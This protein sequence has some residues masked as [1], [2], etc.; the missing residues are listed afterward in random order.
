MVHGDLGSLGQSPSG[1]TRATIDTEFVDPLRARMAFPRERRFALIPAAGSGMRAGLSIP[2]QYEVIAGRPMIDWTLDAFRRSRLVD[3]TYVILSRD[4]ARFTFAS[5]A[6]VPMYV[7]GK[8]R[9]DSVLA[10]LDAIAPTTDARDWILVH[11]AA[12]PG[13]DVALLDHT[14]ERLAQDEVGGLLALPIADTLKR[15]TDDE[16][17]EATI[18]RAMLWAAQT[19]QMFRYGAL[20]NALRASPNATDEASAIEAAG[21]KPKLVLGEL[22]NF[23]VTFRSDFEVAATLLAARP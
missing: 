8:T 16:R 5:D 21:L 2:K 6:I 17:V 3:K 22:S 14:I 12:R 4:D 1:L 7:G 19:P 10:G 9:R 23:K 18:A 11:D 15:S 13:L 20:C